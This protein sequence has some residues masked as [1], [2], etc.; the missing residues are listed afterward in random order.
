M[1]DYVNN[2]YFYDYDL[3]TPLAQVFDMLLHA[4]TYAPSSVSIYVSSVTLL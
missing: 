2:N 1:S 3:A 4:I